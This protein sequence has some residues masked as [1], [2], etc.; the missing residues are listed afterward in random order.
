MAKSNPESLKPIAG[1]A[2]YVDEDDDTGYWCVFGSDSGFSY[3]SGMDKE[4]AERWLEEHPGGN[5]EAKTEL[6]LFCEEQKITAECTYK[7]KE[8]WGDNLAHSWKCILHFG[9]RSLDAGPYFQGSAFE[10]EPPT[11]ADVL[12]CL[13]NS[14]NSG[15]QTFEDYCS[16]F[17]A[18][19]DSR[20][21]YATWQTCHR[22]APKLKRFL[23]NKFEEARGKEH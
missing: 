1:E 18:N 2:R 6:E 13:I 8:K 19:S 4:Q 21:E 7:G 5:P 17:G 16:E 3:Y 11:A 23:G 15:E 12:H 20:K 9:R 22:M 14:A 10:R